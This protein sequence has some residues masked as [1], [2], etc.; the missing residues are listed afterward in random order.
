[1]AIVY[2]MLF[3][4]S[5]FGEDDDLEMLLALS[6]AL[7]TNKLQGNVIE[8]Q[9]LNLHSR[10]KSL[11]YQGL[12]QLNYRMSFSTFTKFLLLL[13]KDLMVDAK[14]SRNR[15]SNQDTIGPE[16]ILHCTLWFLSGTS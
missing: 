14:K 4:A 2:G 10:V 13:G 12:F 6:V 5:H 1:M 11:K 15:T 7:L 16:M 3:P 9:L 8:S